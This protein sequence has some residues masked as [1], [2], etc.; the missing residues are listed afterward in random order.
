[1]MD[2]SLQKMSDDHT[3]PS[4]TCPPERRPVYPLNDNGGEKT[5]EPPRVHHGVRV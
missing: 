3:E 4:G 5:A 2:V 1:M